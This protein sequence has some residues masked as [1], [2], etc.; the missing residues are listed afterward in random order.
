MLNLMEDERNKQVS[1]DQMYQAEASEKPV[2]S[3]YKPRSLIFER[4]PTRYAWFALDSSDD[5]KER[6]GIWKKMKKHNNIAQNVYSTKRSANITCT[7]QQTRKRSIQKTSETVVRYRNKR[8]HL[9][10][11]NLVTKGNSGQESKCEDKNEIMKDEV[12]SYQVA[13]TITEE[14]LKF[15]DTME[16]RKSPPFAETQNY[17]QHN[18]MTNTIT[19][20]EQHSEAHVLEVKSS[21]SSDKPTETKH[22]I[23]KQDAL[24]LCASPEPADMKKYFMTVADTNS[25]ETCEKIGRPQSQFLETNKEKDQ[26]LIS[27]DPN[28][29]RIFGRTSDNLSSLKTEA[30]KFSFGSSTTDTPYREAIVFSARDRQRNQ[31]EPDVLKQNTLK[32]RKHEETTNRNRNNINNCNDTVQAKGEN[33]LSAEYLSQQEKDDIQVKQNSGKEIFS[34][35]TNPSRE[36]K[37]GIQRQTD[38][39]VQPMVENEQTEESENQNVYN[40][41]DMTISSLNEEPNAESTETICK[42]CLALQ[43]AEKFNYKSFSVVIDT[44]TEINQKP[45]EG[46]VIYNE[47]QEAVKTESQKVNHESV[48]G[49]PE[50]HYFTDTRCEI[51]DVSDIEICVSSARKLGLD[52]TQTEQVLTDDPIVSSS[53][54]KNVGVEHT[55]TST[56]PVTSPPKQDLVEPKSSVSSENSQV[57]ENDS[58]ASVES[59]GTDQQTKVKKHKYG[60][61]TKLF[62]RLHKRKMKKVI[63]CDIVSTPSKSCS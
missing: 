17:L 13:K 34:Q 29:N 49:K 41:K 58:Q 56:I 32:M 47:K 57:V 52:T 43:A 54:Y 19:S 38:G 21:D 63:E 33:V 6:D 50:P 59:L 48:C 18:D 12:T 23:A 51:N 31:N 26:N 35:S 3:V 28:E 46:D 1:E 55:E 61:F 39:T 45:S 15:E 22:D 53:A 44:L 24:R 27:N 9:K 11:E 37:Y 8:I 62:A 16:H 25:F 7:K 42:T 14:S 10:E 40:K 30:V 60:W 20:A 4:Q 5:L 2:E 36:D